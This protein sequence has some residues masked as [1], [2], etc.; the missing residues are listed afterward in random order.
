MAKLAS[1]PNHHPFPV[2]RQ[3]NLETSGDTMSYLSP[4]P[5]CEWMLWKPGN[6]QA[7]TSGGS[8]RHTQEIQ[9]DRDYLP[10]S[11]SPHHLCLFVTLGKLL[12]WGHHPCFLKSPVDWDRERA[13]M[14]KIG[15]WVGDTIPT[16]AHVTMTLKI[17]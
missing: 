7:G 17:A 8:T 11:F 10:T 6:T 13:T 9:R 15:H 4:R 12:A 2:S 1:V 14:A 16:M 5:R 3:V